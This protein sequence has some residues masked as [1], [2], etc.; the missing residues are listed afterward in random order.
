MG[1]QI[2]TFEKK[3][4]QRRTVRDTRGIA[5]G[6]KINWSAYGLRTDRLQISSHIA[7]GLTRN[8]LHEKGAGI[9]GVDFP[10][11]EGHAPD[12]LSTGQT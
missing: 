8:Q 2:K 5:E 4:C 11:V 12:S 9:R 6:G 10:N 7:S 3:S 1:C